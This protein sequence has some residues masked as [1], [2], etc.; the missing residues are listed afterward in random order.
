MKTLQHRAGQAFAVAEAVQ[1]ALR[2]PESA[3]T[4]LERTARRRLVCD[5]AG[6]KQLLVDEPAF[7]GFVRLDREGRELYLNAGQLT[8][9]TAGRLLATG[10][11]LFGL[12]SPAAAVGRAQAHSSAQSAG[13]DWHTTRDRLD[14]ADAASRTGELMAA[15]GAHLLPGQSVAGVHVSDILRESVFLD[16]A[17]TRLQD[18]CYGIELT[19]VVIGDSGPQMVSATR[20]AT[21]LDDIDLAGLGR[22]LSLI[23][24]GM[25]TGEHAFAGSRVVFAPSAV[26]QLLRALVNTILLNP[27]AHSAP[28][29]TSLVDEGPCTEGYGGRSFDC[30]GTATGSTQLVGR[31]GWQHVLATRKTVL[32]HTEAPASEPLTGHAWWN[33]L[34]NF[35]QLTAG[36][37]RL[38]STPDAMADSL[39]SGERCVVVDARTLGV[40]EFRSG[41]QLAFRLLATRAVD[42]V[43]VAAYSP[44]SVEGSAI[45]FLS[46]IT[47]VAD[48]VSYFP[49]QVS[50]AGAYLEMDVTPI[51]SKAI[52][53]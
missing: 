41:G 14:M 49:G 35:P 30:E 43:P 38:T 5:A 24:A 2:P 40:E 12:G 47:A 17:G 36:N 45:D 28:L 22:E 26:A 27:V 7:S 29:V 39:L 11:R 18:Q 33:P 31:D 3:A 6:K 44:M 34:K 19:A 1:S 16:S 52:P 37:V 48:T 32:A 42:G 53:S 4:F 20:Y 51:T 21:T 50:A 10:R 15:I 23:H 46:A 8:E 25:G 13:G 9:P